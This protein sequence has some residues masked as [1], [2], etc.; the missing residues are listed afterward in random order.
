MSLWQVA[1]DIEELSY[2]L[3]N[4][5]DMVE[6]VAED[7]DSP[8]SGALWVIKDMIEHIED[9]VAKQADAIMELHRADLKKAK[10]K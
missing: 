6:L 3:A 2:K 4:V 10:K 1:N 7:V 5:R 8:Y 9:K